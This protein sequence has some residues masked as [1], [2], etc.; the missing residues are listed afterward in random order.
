LVTFSRPKTD[1]ESAVR[2]DQ[3]GHASIGSISERID[4]SCLKIEVL[5]AQTVGEDVLAAK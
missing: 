5:T 1:Q 3:F 4:R 2:T